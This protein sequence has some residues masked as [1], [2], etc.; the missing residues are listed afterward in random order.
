ML[1]SFSTA[2]TLC[3]IGTSSSFELG[4]IIIIIGV[5]TITIIV[6][7]IGIAGVALYKGYKTRRITRQK[8]TEV[9]AKRLKECEQNQVD[10]AQNPNPIPQLE[11]TLKYLQESHKTLQKE[12]ARRLAADAAEEGN[13]EMFHQTVQKEYARLPATTNELRAGRTIIST[14]SGTSTNSSA[15]ASSTT[16]L[17][18]RKAVNTA[19]SYHKTHLPTIPKMDQDNTRRKVSIV[20]EPMLSTGCSSPLHGSG[21]KVWDQGDSELLPFQDNIELQSL[22]PSRAASTG[23]QNWESHTDTK[24][25]CTDTR[26]GVTN[27]LGS[28]VSPMPPFVDPIHILECDSCGKEFSNIIHS[29][30][31]RVPEGAIP[32]GV[33]VH[34]EAGVALY[35]PFQFPPGTR[36]ISPIVWFCMQ[37]NIPFEKPVEVILP[38]FLHNWED[39]Q[40]GFLKA[41]HTT[42]TANDGEKKYIFQPVNGSA[43]FLSENDR[44][45]GVLS[46]KHFCF[47]CIQANITRDQLPSKAWYCLS[48]VTPEPWPPT[49]KVPIH[50]CVTFFMEACFQVSGY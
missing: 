25:D 40:L 29:I 20:M 32:D 14:Q 43:E 7:V 34:I 10:L 31:L 33:T 13:E 50:F 2:A 37:E 8:A 16:P 45:F 38:H 24:P 44:G 9:L 1:P 26:E 35:G 49:Q 12:Y 23:T 15:S 27:T 21:R 39:L 22:E 42:Q 11:Q 3:S 4:Y 46:T 17:L 48:D 28:Q 5:V 19:Q 36:P 41:D 6:L 18:S 47:L 30:T